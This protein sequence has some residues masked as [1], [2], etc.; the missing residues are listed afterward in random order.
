M[1][2]V[3]RR[4]SVDRGDGRTS[5]VIGARLSKWREALLVTWAV[6]WL[7]CGVYVIYARTTITPGDP[8]RQYLLAFLAF[9]AYFLLRAVKAVLWRL[10]GFELWRIKEGRVTIKDSTLG[11]GTARTYF[12]ENIQRLG[13]IKQEPTSLKWQLNN[14]DWVIGGERLGFEHLGRKVVFGKGLDEAEAKA[15]LKLLEQELR[16]ERKA[17]GA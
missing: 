13:L 1:E 10:K 7:L 15:L 3:S 8:L 6:A 9:W 12:V 14:S 2:Y 16:R 4:V 11:F 5:V 17:V